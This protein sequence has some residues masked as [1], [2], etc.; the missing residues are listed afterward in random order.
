MIKRRIGI[1]LLLLCLGL[2]CIQC[3]AQAASTEDAVEPIVPEKPCALT[4][5]YCYDGTAF[6]DIPVKLYRIADVAADFRYTF[7]ASFAASNL[8][9]NGIRTQGEW[10]VVRS[11]LEAYIL[12]HGIQ[13]DYIVATDANGRVC[14]EA[15]NTGLYLAVV[16]D[17]M[18]GDL[19]CYF[20]SALV[21]LPGLGTDGYWQYQVEVYA[22]A[23][24]LPPIGPDGERELRV[25]KLWKG[26]QGRD[27]RPERVEIEIYRDGII[28]ETVTLSEENHWS[29]SWL[30]PNDGASWMVA[31]RNVPDGYTMTVETRE[32]AFVV[33]NTRITE[34][35]PIDPPKTG[36]TFNFLLPILLLGIS[37]SMLILLS[38]T[39]K[40]NDS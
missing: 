12:A 26:D 18:Q 15:L 5:Y 37:G 24:M 13:A 10:N 17:A 16:G 8:V 23:E 39:G 32:T 30:V 28:Q 7:T 40:R 29:Y 3:Y 1:L 14:L 6:A 38:M 19:H 33:T 27:E 35:P 31:E 21:S 22:K 36:A 34:E 20:G 9:I 2:S 4:L 11:T 25:L